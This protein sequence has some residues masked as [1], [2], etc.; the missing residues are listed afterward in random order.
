ME[1][2]GH[3]SE[4]SSGKGWISSLIH[5]V[6]SCYAELISNPFKSGL[7]YFAAGLVPALIVGWLIFPMLLYSKQQQ[8]INFNHALHMHPEIVEGIK[9]NTK[10]EKPPK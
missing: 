4:N 2:K 8:P 5:T 3:S 7:A 6:L 10:A 9:G 1:N